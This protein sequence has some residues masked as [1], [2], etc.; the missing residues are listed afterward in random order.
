MSTTVLH[1]GHAPH[2]FMLSSKIIQVVTMDNFVNN[3]SY[4]LEIA[5]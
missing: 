1:L 2:A 5:D 4:A 3:T